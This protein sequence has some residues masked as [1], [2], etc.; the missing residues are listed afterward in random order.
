M[1]SADGERAT[2][3]ASRWPVSQIV[4]LTLL[5]GSVLCAS[6]VA[7]ASAP[8]AIT[9]PGPVFDVLGDTTVHDAE[10]PLI[11][12]VDAET[13]ATDGVLDM[14][15]INAN[16]PDSLP[17]WLQVLEAYF[18]PSRSVLP[19]EAVYPPSSDLTPE[20][21]NDLLMQESQTAA[22]AA[23]LRHLGYETEAELR[24]A[25]IEPGSPARGVLE[26]EDRIL[27]VNGQPLTD[28]TDIREILAA[29]GFDQPAELVIVRDGAEQTVEVTPAPGSDDPN[30]PRLGVQI[31]T[32]VDWPVDVRIQLENV[33]GPSAGMMFALGIIDKLTP[34]SLTGGEVIAGTGTIDGDGEV[35]PIGG[36]RQKLFGAL[37]AGAD[38]FLAPAG[39]CDE[40]VGHV[41]GDLQ[42]V[43]VSTLDEALAALDVI[44]SH[45]DTAALPTCE[46]ALATAR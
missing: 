5:A 15:T 11:E 40:V 18:D 30:A 44:S 33:G 37:G 45:G 9:R 27:S 34:E 31:A 22:I 13:Y 14:L 26:V 23:A 10:V 17:T 8:Y 7:S 3:G 29:N 32:S 4:G 28:V 16:G 35:G 24:V 20:E 25:E 36:I 46:T 2:R 39:N 21:R 6:V 41:P 42:V 12:I 43:A 38:W 1:R 19:I